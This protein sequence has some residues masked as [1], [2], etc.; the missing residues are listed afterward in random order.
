M[1]LLKRQLAIHIQ[2]DNRSVISTSSKQSAR[3]H[4]IR[5]QSNSFSPELFKSPS[6]IKDKVAQLPLSALKLLGGNGASSVEDLSTQRTNKKAAA[7]GISATTTKRSV[8]K[9]G[10]G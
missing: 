8:S 1:S 9:L 3:N 6:L 4:H 10:G 5:K 7:G 2:D